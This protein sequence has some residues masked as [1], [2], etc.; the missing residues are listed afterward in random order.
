LPAVPRFTASGDVVPLS[1]PPSFL[2]PLSAVLP[3]VVFPM[4][5]GLPL[6]VFPVLA[7]LQLSVVFP[8]SVLSPLSVVSPSSAVLP[9]SARAPSMIPALSAPPQAAPSEASKRAAPVLDRLDCIIPV[10][11]SCFMKP[12]FL[13]FH[14]R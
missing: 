7:G 6:V 1:V 9:A 2:P 3:L 4:L 5:A 11:V 14:W 13:L 12:T 10:A 8:M